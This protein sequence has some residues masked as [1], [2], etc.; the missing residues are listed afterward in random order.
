M[1][2][3]KLQ[4]KFRFA[5]YSLLGA[6]V[7][8]CVVLF[9][10]VRPLQIHNQQRSFDK[11]EA[12]L[13]TLATQVQEKI[14]KANEIKKTKSCDRANL[15]NAKGP[16][17]C[18]IS[19]GLLYLDSNST[20]SSEKMISISDFL[21]SPVR[22]GSGAT[23]GSTFLSRSTTNGLQIFYSDVEN[24]DKL[25]CSASFRYPSTVDEKLAD[26]QI[27]QFL[28][29]LSCGGSAYKEYYPLKD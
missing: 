20:Q 9:F 1:A 14:G 16:L 7:L 3:K 22:I 10:V 27:E 6:G 26:T 18:D 5:I 29:N 21:K 11:A 25:S 12:N 24:V 4:S 2:Q 15:L 17:G 8:G 19:V 28:V 13:D 23:H